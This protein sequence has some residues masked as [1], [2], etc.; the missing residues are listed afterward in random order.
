MHTVTAAL[1][2]ETEKREKLLPSLLWFWVI[3]EEVQYPDGVCSL[4]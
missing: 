4:K 2:F 1:R 3:L